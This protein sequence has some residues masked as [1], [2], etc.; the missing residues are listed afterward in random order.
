M[1]TKPFPDKLVEY[2]RVN[3]GFS[4]RKYRLVHVMSRGKYSEVLLYY[5]LRRT[6][7]REQLNS[8]SVNSIRPISALQE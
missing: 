7:N 1:L 8:D 5:Q 4:L 2:R 6:E 3:D